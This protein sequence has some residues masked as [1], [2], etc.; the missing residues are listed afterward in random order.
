MP[1]TSLQFN[2]GARIHEGGARRC[3]WQLVVAKGGSV[4]VGG[5]KERD[6]SGAD[7]DGRVEA[8]VFGVVFGV[9]SQARAFQ[10]LTESREGGLHGTRGSERRV[11][12]GLRGVGVGEGVGGGGRRGEAMAEYSSRT[13]CGSSDSR[14]SKAQSRDQ[15]RQNVDNSGLDVGVFG[16]GCKTND[17]VPREIAKT[18]TEAF[19]AVN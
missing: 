10:T 19:L 13:S 8:V 5:R 11:T 7:G 6:A 16:Y 14:S 2:T 9:S 17:L 4:E 3:W 15:A 1:S 12:R 18:P